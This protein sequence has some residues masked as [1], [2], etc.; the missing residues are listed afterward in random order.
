MEK[1]STYFCVEKV[2]AQKKIGWVHID[3]DKLGMD[4]KF[5]SPYFEQLSS[6]VTVSEECANI[7]KKR[8]PD[9]KDKVEVMYNIVSPTMIKNMAESGF[10]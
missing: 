6:I 9:Q 2:D 3:Y 4:P 10:K 7:F 8:F 1:T 5:D